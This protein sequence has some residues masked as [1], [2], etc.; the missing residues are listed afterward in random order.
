VATVPDFATATLQAAGVSYP[1][2]KG[3]TIFFYGPGQTFQQVSFVDVL[4]P[5]TW[6]KQFQSG[7]FFQDKIVI[8]GSTATILQDFHATPFGH[9]GSLMAGIEIHAN[10]I[11]SLLEGRTIVDVIP[12]AP[13]KGV[14]VLCSV[15][16]AA[17]W[18]SRPK[19]PLHRWCWGMGLAIAWMGI[20][21]VSFIYGGLII[22][23]AIPVGAI[24]LTACSLLLT[25][26][27]REQMRK[28]QLRAAL[29]QY[30]TSPIVQEIISQ[31]EDLQDLLRDRELA[32]A[33]KLLSH[34]YCIIRVLGSGGFSE[35]Y[36]AED[37]QRP[38]NPLC[39]VKQLRVANNNLHALKMARRLFATEAET[40]EKLG[41]HDQIPHLLACF[42]ENEE[43]Y[44]VQ[45]F[46]PGHPLSRELLPHYSLIEPEVIKLLY[47]LLH[48]LEFVHHHGVIHRDLKPSNIIRRQTDGKLVL[49]DFGIAKKI[50]TQLATAEHN[51]KF[52]VAVGTPGYMPGEQAAGRPSFNSD[53]YALGMIGIQALTGTSPHLLQ[54][55]TKTGEILWHNPD[56]QVSPAFATILDKMVQQD[57]TQRYLSAQEVREALERLPGFAHANLPTAPTFD[58]PLFESFDLEQEED[59]NTSYTVALP[60]DWSQEKSHHS[61]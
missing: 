19:Q 40:L 34:R 48:I 1:T 37:T 5:D 31:Q 8:I 25:G 30:V 26:T 47:E 41:Q 55:D 42:E 33:G 6:E 10:A 49:I 61:S 32:L 20:G 57:F 11:A 46:I 29:Q 36:V 59:T 23:T 17:W 53:I 18:S 43:F 45:E 38:G 50:T 44:L 56:L 9:D 27:A 51:T 15:V 16:L 22:P 7:Q 58:S 4:D 28:R 13:V 54:H 14:F 2:P 35:T 12:S 3:T 39:V 52:T 24:A 21:Y 60:D